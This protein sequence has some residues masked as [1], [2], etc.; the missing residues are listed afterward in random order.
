MSEA[1]PPDHV[2]E[3]LLSSAQK[4]LHRGEIGEALTLYQSALSLDPG[5]GMANYW[6]GVLALKSLEYPEAAA[7]LEMAVAKHPDF[8]DFQLDLGL[9]YRALDQGARAEVCFAAARR[10]APDYGQAQ[11]NFAANFERESRFNEAVEAC[12]RGLALFPESLEL[13]QKLAN[14]HSRKQEWSEALSVWERILELKPACA[15]AHFAFGENCFRAGEF[16]LARNAFQRTID[17]EPG[18]L[19]ARLN[20]GLA[21]QKLGE[22][23]PA[24]ECFRHAS[25]ASPENC[26]IHKGLGDLYRELEQWPEAIASWQ[27]AVDLRP[28]YAD[29]WQNLGLGLECQHR[30]DEAL[31]C[32][33]R[34]VQLLPN[35][36][37]AVRYLGMVCQDLGRLDEARDCYRKALRLAPKDPEVH[38]QLFSLQAS[39][40]EFPQAWEEHEWRWHIKS[41][42]TPKRNF[43]QPVW[44]GASLQGRTLLLHAEQ[45]FGDTI[46]TARY[47]PLIRE[48]GG[49]V[50]LWC[51][52]DLTFLLGTIAGVTSVFSQ[53][54]PEIRFDTHLP[55]MSLPHVFKTTLK[56]IPAQVP[57]LRAPANA[58]ISFPK[59]SGRNPKI[60]LSWCG[61]LSQ[62]NDQRPIPFGLLEPIVHMAGTDFFS[63]QKGARSLSAQEASWAG[64]V[65]DLSEQLT[66]FG[67]TAAAIENLD[68]LI[69]VDTAIA[70]LAGALGKPVWVLLSF[71]PDWRWMRDRED[72]PWYPTMRLFRQSSPGDWKSV[73]EKLG[74]ALATW[75]AQWHWSATLNSW[76]GKGLVHHQSG[77]LDQAEE[78]YRLVLERDPEHSD[79]MRFMGVLFRQRGDL[80]SA[81]IWMEKALQFGPSSA[82]VNHDLGL[83]RF[84]LGRIEEAIRF[85]RRALEIKPDFPEAHYNLGNAYYAAKRA[86]EAVNAYSSAIAQ[87][88]SMADAYYNLGLLAQEEGEI[89]RAISLYEAVIRLEPVHTNAM[90][91][92]GLALKDTARLNEAE[93]CFRRLLNHDATHYRARVNLASVLTSKGELDAAETLCLEVLS[94][95]PN[96]AEAWLNLGVIR[97]ALG[98]IPS[99]IE[100]FERSLALKPDYADARYN[101]GIAQLLSGNLEFGWMNYEARWL[102]NVPVFAKRPFSMPLW[103]GEDLKGRTLLVHS[104][105]GYGDTIQFVRFP[106]V[107]A[108]LGARIVL[109][110]PDSLA[111]LLKTVPGIARVVPTGEQL[112]D[113]DFHLPLMSFP[114]CL[115]TTLETIPNDIPYLGVPDATEISTPARSKSRIKVGL[116][117]A[118]NPSHGADRARSIPYGELWP[119]WS[120]SG[121]QFY[122]L[123]VGV[124]NQAGNREKK[125]MPIIDLETQLVDF[126]HTAAAIQKMDLVIC[127]D[128]AVAHLSGALGKPVWILLPFA[129]DWRW[130]TERTTSPWYPQARLFRQRKRGDWS[131]VI[132]EAAAALREFIRQE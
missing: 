53:M 62:P 10:N 43:A 49:K 8:P 48:R 4:A 102:S 27:T 38:W 129:P 59:V 68:L 18:T 23:K 84:E 73:F 94:S 117:W 60:G 55:M 130:L 21:F 37:T 97:Q 75:N 131:F 9:A 6:L 14:L 30:L 74:A 118:G 83:I 128:T 121:A 105:Q 16:E 91:N 39:L 50:L 112:P 45:G 110:C 116:A 119:L 33:Q 108:G 69:T 52:P 104:E 76:L 31:A 7:C 98:E 85:Y 89:E 47:V 109:E 111:R 103:K 36:A 58:K 40:G 124:A 132:N 127:V 71:A 96:L 44:D 82:Q 17:L 95:E 11:L 41:R 67:Q 25:A 29:A 28:N 80:E 51:P 72:C 46:Q 77:R 101:L 64:R 81:R 88:P 54:R 35:D 126:A 20:L 78:F 125:R 99:A 87:Q 42:T 5:H 57:Y 2:I 15:S 22:F 34:V 114:F 66:D 63:L 65:S 1:P 120:C 115:K 3:E 61:S 13:L 86:D 123:Q 24:I 90:L 19:N 93:R 122:S 106:A 70:H 113:C 92:L 32:H 100:S 12:K 26:E 107:A 79:A 56:T